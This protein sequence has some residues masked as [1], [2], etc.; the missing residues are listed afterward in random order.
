M[1]VISSENVYNIEKKS[2]KRKIS[3]HKIFGVTVSKKSFEFILHIP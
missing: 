2:I 3:I 1:I